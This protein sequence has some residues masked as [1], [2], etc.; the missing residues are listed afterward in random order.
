MGVRVPDMEVLLAGGVTKTIRDLKIGDKLDTLHQHTLKRGEAEISYVRIV[1]SPLVNLNFSG[2]KFTCSEEDRF[3]SP[4][5][6]SWLS[7]IDLEEG[8]KVSQLD[9]ELEFTDS[10]K[11]GTGDSVEIIVEGAHTYVCDGVLLHNGNKEQVGPPP[12]VFVPS[13][14][15]PPTIVHEITPK[16]TYQQMADVMRRNHELR[17]NLEQ[18]DFDRGVTPLQQR[19]NRDR[20]ELAYA[21]KEDRTDA[22]SH[23]REL[24][25]AGYSGKEAFEMAQDREPSE[26]TLRAQRAYDLAQ[27]RRDE[28]IATGFQPTEEFREPAWADMDWEP[29]Y[30]DWRDR[31]IYVEPRDPKPDVFYPDRAPLADDSGGGGGFLGLCDERLKVDIAPLE[32]TEV[33]DALAEVAFFVKGLR[34]CA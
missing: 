31:N 8:D 4:S 7:A 34:E 25:N 20:T 2:R 9:G 1:E 18:K 14:P 13:A 16:A 19:L 29:I 6:K 30:E 27:S 23:K 17:Q 5:R 26:R 21:Q 32:S 28:E 10:E 33:N 22:R 24:R 3:Y 11:L 12:P 15:T